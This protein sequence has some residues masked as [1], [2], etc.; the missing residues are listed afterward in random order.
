VILVVSQRD[1]P[2]AYFIKLGAKTKL[3]DEVHEDLQFTNRDLAYNYIEN[4]MGRR[5]R[6][7]KDEFDIYWEF[8]YPLPYL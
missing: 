6:R 8:N 3:F 2:S 5:F 1:V 7:S 4:D